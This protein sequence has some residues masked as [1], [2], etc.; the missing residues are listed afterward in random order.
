MLYEAWK[1]LTSVCTLSVKQ[2]P[3]LDAIQGFS[4]HSPLH[5]VNHTFKGCSGVRRGPPKKLWTDSF[6]HL[7]HRYLNAENPGEVIWHSSKSRKT[8]W[9]ED[10]Y[11]LV[12]TS[13]S[14]L[15]MNRNRV[16]NYKASQVMQQ[17]KESSFSCM[18]LHTTSLKI[19]KL[20]FT[21]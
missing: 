12:S 19:W 14:S 16:S 17:H 3:C 9:V 1:T 4:L 6:L 7:A 18:H 10:N 15:I 5:L 11:F 21:C 20:S 2:E 13:H 8:L